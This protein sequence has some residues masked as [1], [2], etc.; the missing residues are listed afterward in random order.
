M[1]LITPLLLLIIFFLTYL[2]YLQ[3]LNTQVELK[4]VVPKQALFF[5][6]QQT[7]K[8]FKDASPSVAYITTKVTMRDYWSRNVFSVPQGS[9]SGF[10]WDEQGHIVTNYHVIQNA[11][12]ATI[13]FNN[14]KNYQ[15]SLVGASPQHDLAV[16]KI[17]TVF[18]KLKPIKVGTS[19]DL[20]VGQKTF[21][22]GNPFGLD[23]TLTSGIISALDRTLQIE[24]NFAIEHLIQ[25]DAA[26]NPGNSGG[27]LLDSSGR[28][29]GINT[30]IYSPSGAYAGIGF[31]VPIDT[32][33]KVVSSI[34]QNGKYIRPTLGI[35]I[36][37][38]INQMLKKEY[39]IDGVV[40]LDVKK[41]SSA[42]SSGLQG[43]QKDSYNN[44]ILGD[45]ITSING[46]KIIST[47]NLLNLLDEYNV[48]EKIEVTVLRK[49]KNISFSITLE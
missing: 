35:V 21:A 24:K 3:P 16:L 28:L 6:E 43:V 48:G 4:E 42:E 10:I 12:E 5:D 17:F 34:I 41:G 40:V 37:D 19:S 22:I 20:E 25:T 30:A 36:N 45:I 23:Y 38:E 46:N 31:A 1:R 49:D 44:M 26:I 15:A 11:S 7:I 18:D 9:G 2:L 29:I 33:N 39:G 27:P 32:V 14:G 13:H 8:L 47:P